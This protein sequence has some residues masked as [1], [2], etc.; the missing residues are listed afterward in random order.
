[1]KKIL[2]FAGILSVFI[3]ILAGF[4]FIGDFGGFANFLGGKSKDII[5]IE[6]NKFVGKWDID[7]EKQ[8]VEFCSNKTVNGYFE[9]NYEFTAKKIFINTTFNDEIITFQYSYFFSDNDDTLTISEIE[10]G[11]GFILHKL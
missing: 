4:I 9:G 7:N 2:L 8:Q 3:L 1:M 11:K 5:D 6:T 10:S